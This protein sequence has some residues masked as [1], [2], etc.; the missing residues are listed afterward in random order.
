M[1]LLLEIVEEDI[2]NLNKDSLI[3]KI[4]IKL[5]LLKDSQLKK[6]KL[7]LRLI[8]INF[9]SRLKKSLNDYIYNI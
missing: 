4:I 3:S 5:T 7:R 1:K 8:N 2:N 9:N 6:R